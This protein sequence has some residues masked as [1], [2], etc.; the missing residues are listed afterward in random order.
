MFCGMNGYRPIA[1]NRFSASVK[2]NFPASEEHRQK[3]EPEQWPELQANKKYRG[4]RGITFFKE[5]V[6]EVLS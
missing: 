5:G 2:R 4:F 6:P 3:V 1:T